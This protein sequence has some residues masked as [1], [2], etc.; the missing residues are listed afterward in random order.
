MIFPSRRP[1]SDMLP[2]IARIALALATLI[3][4]AAMLILVAG[5]GAH[6]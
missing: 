4:I 6:Y 3:L 2:D 5:Y 1:P